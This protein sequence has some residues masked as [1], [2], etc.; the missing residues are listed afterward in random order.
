LFLLKLA[1]SRAPD[2]EDLDRLA[3]RTAMC[4][5]RHGVSI[6]CHRLDEIRFDWVMSSL[7]PAWSLDAARRIAM[8]LWPEFE[9]VAGSSANVA[10]IIVPPRSSSI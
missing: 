9:I 1:A 8:H 10:H 7:H 4:R 3:R 5:T 6:T 2:F